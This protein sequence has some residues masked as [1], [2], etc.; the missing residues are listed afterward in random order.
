MG[1]L[2]REKRL[3]KN[4]VLVTRHVRSG[5]ATT[6]TS[7]I[8]APTVM[9]PKKKPTAE[10][11]A[12]N[13]RLKALDR[14]HAVTFSRKKIPIYA[15][16]KLEQFYRNSYSFT[17][18]DNEF[19]SVMEKLT[20]DDT[21][22]LM[23][24]GL[25]SHQL[26][27]FVTKQYP[28]SVDNSQLVAG[29]KKRAIPLKSYLEVR[30]HHSIEHHGRE[31]ILNAAEAH[32]MLSPYAK[33]NYEYVRETY[34]RYVGAGVIDVEDMKAL[35][36]SRC[37]QYMADFSSTLIALKKKDSKCTAEELGEMINRVE[38]NL[39]SSNPASSLTSSRASVMVE[40]DTK[41]EVCV[42]A[43]LAVRYGVDFTESISSTAVLFYGEEIAKAMK[44]S[45]AKEFLTYAD[46][47]SFG[48]QTIDYYGSG[49]EN[50]LKQV[51]E[52]WEAGITS[53]AA[54]EGLEDGLTVQQIIGVE[55]DGISSSV[56][57]GWL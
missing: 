17:C 32:A 27:E 56:A 41:M 28:Y 38:D 3:D 45:S 8:P 5:P 19:Y 6:D 53:K 15:N 9:T 25:R 22:V 21:V 40:A 37:D 12:Y 39:K 33:D 26:D 46:D 54:R 18:S 43:R 14:Q 51:H 20:F 31:A 11:T 35:G 13:R 1:N 4:G 44:E 10:A 36:I 34:I 23:A 42:R 7:K 47:A 29:L 50:L 2:V 48:D 57:T 52:L 24:A 16:W 49:Q 30:T 55:Q